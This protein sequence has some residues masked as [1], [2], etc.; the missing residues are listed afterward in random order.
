MEDQDQ[1]FNSAWPL[2]GITPKDNQIELF[3]PEAEP[4][5]N[6]VATQKLF[7]FDQDGNITITYYTIEGHLIIYYREELKNPKQE[8]YFTKRLREPRG[9][10]RYWMPRGQKP[11]PWFHPIT[12]KAFQEKQKIIRL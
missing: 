4:P 5:M 6:K 9:D 1:Y 8:R 2:L 3:N 10:M 7:W 12:V 11:K